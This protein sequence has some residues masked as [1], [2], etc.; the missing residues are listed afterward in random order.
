MCAG[1]WVFRWRRWIGRLLEALNQIP[2]PSLFLGVDGAQVAW[3][4]AEALVFLRCF[5]FFI[6]FF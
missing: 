5:L 6:Y 4:T 1:S 2:A 3:L